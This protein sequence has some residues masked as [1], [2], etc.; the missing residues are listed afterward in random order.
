[1]NLDPGKL[2]DWGALY[3]GLI[4]AG[5]NI[6]TDDNTQFQ[7]ISTPQLAAW[8]TST[9]QYYA[10][11]WGNNA[12]GSLGPTATGP[13]VDVT[14]GY[15]QFIYSLQMPK[16][17]DP[18]YLN[19]IKQQA[20]L[21]DQLNGE[22]AQA[23]G[24]YKVWVASNASYFPNVKSFA[25]WLA[26]ANTGGA[27]YQSKLTSIQQQ[28]TSVNQ[29]LW[30]YLQGVNK[31]LLQ[32]QQALDPSNQVQV[33]IPGSSDTKKIFN[34]RFNPDLADF[35]ATVTAGGT[36]NPANI[37]IGNNYQYTG[38]WHVQVEAGALF[39]YDIFGFEGEGGW[40]RDTDIT[41]DSQFSA[42]LKI[43][44]LQTFN[45]DRDGWM[46]N[47]LIGSY[48]KGPFVG[49][50]ITPDMFFGPKGSLKLVPTSVLVA[51]GT[52]FDLTMSSDSYEQT[53]EKWHA[54]SGIMIGPFFIGGEASG[55]STVVT[56][57]GSTTTISM[58]DN[59]DNNAYVIGV[60]SLAFYNGDS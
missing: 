51:Y 29:Q 37:Q 34:T 40:T 56:Q 7:F 18:N 27:S 22:S 43:K 53:K 17:S 50:S 21:A 1:M 42:T 39:D 23:L 10:D 30:P 58:G 13:Q 60:S 57:K 6:Q 32:A 24:A 16:P 36:V 54:E 26:S 5:L 33:V 48:M 28:L 8:D 15:S 3:D 38:N 46:F 59:K 52:T 45:V 20:A 31:P 55:N 35:L 12:P 11:F 44:G 41:K 9:N 19:L 4:K 14:G 49:T 2:G 25:D 47:N